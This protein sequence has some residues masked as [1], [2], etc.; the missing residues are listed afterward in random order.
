MMHTAD[1]T[2]N[3]TLRY[4]FLALLLIAAAVSLTACQPQEQQPS[5]AASVDTAEVVATIDSL[6]ALYEQTVA[7]GDF[8]TM[9]SMLAEGAV[10]VGPGGPQWDSLRA[11]SEYPWPPGATLDITS[12]ET[13]VLSE[14]WAYDFGTSTA[15]YTPEGASEP[16]TLR[17]TYLLLLRNTEDGWK[18]YREV[19]SPDLPPEA[20]LDQ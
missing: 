16:R 1:R 9:G 10:M 4:S 13:V 5:Q 11:A 6:R 18:L 3:A 7:T 14:E 19:A 12:I 17:D 20:M 8:E 15:T 2:D